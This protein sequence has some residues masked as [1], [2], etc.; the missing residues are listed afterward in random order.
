MPKELDIDSALAKEEQRIKVRVE[1]RRYG[2]LTTVIEG[3]DPKA[4]DV[5]SLTKYLKSKIACGGTHKGDRIELQGDHRKRI[6]Q[7]L[8]DYGFK[9]EQIEVD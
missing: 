3:I 7:L 6:K 9:E 8:V 5:K 4:I 2:K 1:K